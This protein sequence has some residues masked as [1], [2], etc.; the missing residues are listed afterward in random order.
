MGFTKYTQCIAIGLFFLTNVNV[1]LA[2]A[3]EEPVCA[4]GDDT[5]DAAVSDEGTKKYYID[6]EKK[7][8]VDISKTSYIANSGGIGD[9]YEYLESDDNCV[10][11]HAQ[12]KG[13]AAS[14]ECEKNPTFMNKECK[15]SCNSC[16]IDDEMVINKVSGD[17]KGSEVVEDDFDFGS[18]YGV[19][20]KCEGA[21]ADEIKQE[22]RDMDKYMEAEVPD[23]IR[24]LCKNKQDLC[25]YWAHIGECNKNEGWMSETCGPSCRKCH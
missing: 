16:A 21:T 5:C 18:K 23:S 8:P 4:A 3:V 15:F 11:N 12:C 14:E 2:A 25:A 17:S 24:P 19:K 6:K 10:D 9:K 7:R 1:P 13:W 20:Q 22:L